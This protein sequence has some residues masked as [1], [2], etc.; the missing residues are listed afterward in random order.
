MPE[1]RETNLYWFAETVKGTHEE[2]VSLL[3]QEIRKSLCPEKSA[4]ICIE[5]IIPKYRLFLYGAFGVCRDTGAIY[6][7]C[8]NV[9]KEN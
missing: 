4:R 2:K 7:A 3:E 6:Q 8:K 9:I 5:K 1:Y